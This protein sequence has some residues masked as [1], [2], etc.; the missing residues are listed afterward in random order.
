VAAGLDPI[1]ARKREREA[2]KLASTKA[3]TFEQS[4]R[5]YTASHDAGW[6]NSQHRSQWRGTLATYVYPV[7]GP[8]PVEAIETTLVLKALE[9]IWTAKPETAS[10]VRGRIERVLDWAKVR[11]YRDGAN[12]AQWRGHLDHLLPAKRKVRAVEHHAAMPYREVGTLMSNLRAE[13]TVYARCVEFMILTATRR[14]ERLGARWDEFDLDQRM[15]TIPGNR[16]KAGRERG[17]TV[18]ACHRHP[19]GNGRGSP[20]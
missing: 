1:E 18:R 13:S 9:P 12:P 6:R 4:A 17:S 10:R 5:A 11:G 2:A 8:L 7:I 20:Q 15:W 14:G 19:R 3:M 16:M